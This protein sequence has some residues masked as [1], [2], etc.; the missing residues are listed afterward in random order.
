MQQKEAEKELKYGSLIAEI[1]K[2]WYMK[3]MITPTIVRATGIVTEGLK[4][5]EAIPGKHSTDPLHTHTN[6]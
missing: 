6:A 5:L 2:M 1:Q 4:H 3:C